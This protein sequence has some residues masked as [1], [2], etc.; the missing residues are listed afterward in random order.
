MWFS[1]SGEVREIFFF[2]FALFVKPITFLPY[3]YFSFCPYGFTLTD[4]IMSALTCTQTSQVCC[5]V[6]SKIRCTVVGTGLA[7]GRK[8]YAQTWRSSETLLKCFQ[9]QFLKYSYEICGISLLFCSFVSLALEVIKQ[10]LLESSWWIFA[11]NCLSYMVFKCSL[12]LIVLLW[13]IHL[14]LN[15]CPY[16][17]TV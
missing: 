12:C 15:R 16:V 8:R 4:F 1:T 17:F 3:L 11:V 6:K 14:G 7:C 13:G 9:V 2:F 5:L 10:T